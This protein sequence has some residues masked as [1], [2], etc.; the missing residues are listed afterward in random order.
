[1]RAPSLAQGFRRP[2]RP[3]SVVRTP[4][5]APAPPVVPGG[6]RQLCE[7]PAAATAPLFVPGGLCQLCEPSSPPP[8][9]RAATVSCLNPPLRPS[10]PPSVVRIPQ[11]RPRFPRSPQAATVSCANHAGVALVLS[12]RPATVNCGNPRPRLP[13]PRVSV[14]TNRP[15][16]HAPSALLKAAIPRRLSQ[17]GISPSD[18]G[19]SG[20]SACT[21]GSESTP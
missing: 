10:Q 13:R 19:P 11:S 6:H 12:S 7:S 16:V 14:D 18:T 1:V 21:A 3:Q 20:C 15:P 17:N 8:S 4:I 5:L 9:S 2:G